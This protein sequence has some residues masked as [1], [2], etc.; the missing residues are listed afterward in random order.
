MRIAYTVRA[1]DPAEH[2]AR[3]TVD[4]EDVDAPT[5]DLVLPSWVPG[6]YHIV[7]YVRAL[8][9]FSAHRPDDRTPLPIERVDKARWR[10]TRGGARSV[11]VEYSGYGHDLVTEG[12]DLTPDHLLLNAGT[13]LPFVDGHLDDPVELVI[14]APPDWRVVTEL[15]EVGGHP[16]RFRAANYDE[17]LDNPIDVGRPLVVTIRPVGI[18]HRI[19]ICGTGGTY[20][21]HRIEEDLGKIVEATVRLVGD[22]PLASYTFFFHVN[23]VPDGGLE[24]ATS[25]SCVVPRLIYPPDLRYRRFLG[26]VSHE[27]FHLY[28]VKRIRPKAFDR[29]D[30]TRE[31]YT[32]LLWWMEGTTDYLSDVVLLRAGLLPPPKFLEAM[33]ASAKTFL[34]TPGRRGRS[35]EEASLSAWVDYYQP[36]EETPNLSVS[37]YLKGALVSMCLDLEIRHRTDGKASLETVLRA[38]WNDFGKVGR[39]VG[40]EDL[41]P[42]ANRATGLDLTDFFAKYVRGTEELDLDAF[43]R[44]AGLAFGPRPKP[45][46]DDSPDPGYLGIR[47]ETVDGL[48]RVKNVLLDT[49]GRRAGLSPGDEIVAINRMKVVAAQFDKTL[50]SYPPGTAVDLTIF[51]RGYLTQLAVETGRKP[52]EKYAFTPVDAPTE[53][54]KRVHEGWLGAKWEPAKKGDAPASP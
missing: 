17:L 20:E 49:P 6:S 42:V 47:Y 34:D 7:N 28:N 52:P 39:G 8:F 30:Y 10:V 26:L 5:V 19:S 27:Y 16:P 32:R 25:T 44:L 4:L 45:P 37:Y 40:E 1:T 22:S 24:H 31:N 21:T 13:S 15:A 9:D 38:L 41:L 33:A 51:R 2:R 12:F 36:Y 54:A 35:L 18:P 43:A 11:R 46:D 48:V 3:F 29:F 53:L 23:D 50:E 14:V